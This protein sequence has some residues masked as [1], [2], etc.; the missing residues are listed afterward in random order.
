MDLRRYLAGEHA[1]AVPLRA[2]RVR[3]RK[4]GRRRRPRRTRDLTPVASSVARRTLQG[5]LD[6]G[7]D[8]ARVERLLQRVGLAQLSLDLCLEAVWVARNEEDLDGRI[9]CPQLAGNLDPAGVWQSV[10]D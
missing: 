4:S 6:P 7:D 10:V 8:A 3:N 9:P 5:A 2:P 1:D